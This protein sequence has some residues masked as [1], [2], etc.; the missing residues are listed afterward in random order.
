MSAAGVRVTKQAEGGIDQSRKQDGPEQTFREFGGI[1]LID[2]KWT[3][4]PLL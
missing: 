2:E 1:L 4:T 3:A